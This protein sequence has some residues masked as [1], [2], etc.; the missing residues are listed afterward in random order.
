MTT[1]RVLASHALPAV[2]TLVLAGAGCAHTQRTA[3][4]AQPAAAADNGPRMR[5][6]ETNGIKLRIAEMGQGPLVIFLHGFPESWYSWRHQLPATAKAGFH[7]VAPDLRG[8]GKSDKPAGVDDYDIHHLT[9]DVVG[10]IDALGQKTAVVVGHDWGALVAW[11]AVLLHPDRFTGVVAMSVPYGGR[12]AVSP[13]ETMKKTYGDNFYYILYFQEPGVAEA[14][15]DKDPRRF[16]SRLYLS[17]DSPREPPEITDPKRSAGGWSG[18]M[19]ASKGLPSWLTQADLDY[20][21]TEFTESGFRGGINF[22]RNFHRN[23][24]TTPQLADKKITQPAAFI[25][26]DRD[27]VI[28]GASAEQLTATMSRVAT[29]FRGVTLIPSAGHWV[30]QERPEE[31]NA[32]LLAFLAGLSKPKT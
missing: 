13:L 21:V 19:G 11:N 9:A 1:K 4:T 23:W 22:Y 25:A 16:L 7:A 8:Y 24:E 17:P 30:Q 18:R 32:A 12:S 6:V 14:E 20:Y 28:R 10:L 29:D 26:G 15:F 3:A 27:G 5:T 2:C 31:T